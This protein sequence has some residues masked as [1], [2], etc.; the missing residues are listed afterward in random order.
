ME[1]RESSLKQYLWIVLS[2][3]YLYLKYSQDAQTCWVFFQT[4]HMH[5]R[6]HMGTHILKS[7]HL[8]YYS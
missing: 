3:I 5:A 2:H 4:Q 7:L 8:V 6:T 1:L